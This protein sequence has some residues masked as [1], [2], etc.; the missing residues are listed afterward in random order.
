MID[1][2]PDVPR[3]TVELSDEARARAVEI[4]TAIQRAVAAR[5]DVAV[6]IIGVG[7]DALS[8]G[9]RSKPESIVD[10]APWLNLAVDVFNYV[11]TAETTDALDA[12][13]A[14]DLGL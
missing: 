6:S 7:L 3:E 11:L 9:L 2:P 1:D 12:L 14:G 5:P 10:M 4:G 13:R 8:S